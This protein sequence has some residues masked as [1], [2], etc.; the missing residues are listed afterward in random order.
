MPNANLQHESETPSFGSAGQIDVSVRG[1]SVHESVPHVVGVPDVVSVRDSLSRAFT[2]GAEQYASLVPARRSA[3]GL[4]MSAGSSVAGSFSSTYTVPLNGPATE[5][6]DGN[7]NKASVHTLQAA[8]TASMIASGSFMNFFGG[9][10]YCLSPAYAKTGAASVLADMWMTFSLTFGVFVFSAL[11]SALFRHNWAAL[12]ERA[13]L[14]F[15]MLLLVPS[16]LDVIITGLS[17]LAL[18]FA[19]PALVGILKTAS[20]LV[21]LSVASRIVLRKRQPWSHWLCLLAVLFGVVILGVN[22]V[23]EAMGVTSN[24]VVGIC[25]SCGAGALGAWRNLLEAA[26]LA[27]DGFPPNALLLAESALSALVLGLC[28]LTYVLVIPQGSTLDR[29]EDASLENFRDTMRHPLAVASFACYAIFS[30][31]KDSGK[32]WLIK[33]VSALRQKVLALLFPFGTWTIGLIVFYVA[34][35]RYTPS[36]GV[37]WQDPSSLIELSGFVVIL[38]GNAVIVLLKSNPR[39]RL[40]RCC[41]KIDRCDGRDG[42]R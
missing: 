14:Q 7:T 41:A 28:W 10:V 40:S 11:G 8:I 39:S 37:A 33:N 5:D 31:G 1:T 4:N 34:G 35:H 22:A 18:A 12:A 15:V 3:S 20:Q 17:T 42:S 26:I 38:V 16:S 27:D 24:E 32:F 13:T 23:Q 29:Y 2:E 19:Q 30:Y 25:I 9:V 21:A 6:D 36:I